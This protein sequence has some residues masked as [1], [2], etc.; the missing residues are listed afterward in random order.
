MRRC[1]SVAQFFDFPDRSTGDED[2][3]VPELIIDYIRGSPSLDPAATI[4]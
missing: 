1:G 3:A 2:D 4:G